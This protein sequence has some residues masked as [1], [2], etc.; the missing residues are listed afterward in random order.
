MTER[1]V[2]I[3]MAARSLLANRIEDESI[4]QAALEKEADWL[5]QLL[6][7]MGGRPGSMYLKGVR[8]SPEW[9][10]RLLSVNS[11]NLGSVASGLGGGGLGFWLGR[12]SQNKALAQLARQRNLAYAVGGGGALLGLGGLAAAGS[13]R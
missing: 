2:M 5:T 6:G 8:N 9:L 1:E 12:A 11:G 3:K 10:S 4:K 7:R 13:R